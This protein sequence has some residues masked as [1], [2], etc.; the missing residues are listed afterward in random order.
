MMAILYTRLIHWKKQIISLLF[1]L[2]LPI[3]ATLAI[4]YGTSLIQ[5]DSKIPVGIVTGDD[6]EIANA[7]YESIRAT[8]LIRVIDVTEAEAR[9]LVESHEL[10]SAF[11]IG[12]GYGQDVENGRRNRLITSYLS[13]LSFAYAP[14]SQM[15][16]S[17]VQQDTGH[18][19]AAHTVINLSNHT[20]EQWTWDEIVAKTIE[21]QQE[22]DLLRTTFTFANTV[23]MENENTVSLWNTWGLWAL[24]SILSTLLLFDWGVKEK[25]AEILP[26][27]AFIRYTYQHYLLLNVCLYT[28]LFFIFDLIAVVVFHTFLSESI[29]LSLI[30]AILAFR[31]LINMGAFIFTCLFQNVYLYYSTAFLLALITAVISGAII[32]IDGVTNRFP[33]VALFNPVQPFLEMEF[34]SPWHIVCFVII[35]IWYVKGGKSNA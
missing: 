28:L 16:I 10:D 14:V 6:S 20:T 12:E 33:W 19:K 23:G 13:N 4:V 26:R 18:S 24:F 21:I 35:A 5:Q 7:L 11:V 34:I 3:L 15:I 29:S 30:G 9:R 22:E 8:Q 31:M 25:R 1:W 27:F 32:P 2:L 17:L